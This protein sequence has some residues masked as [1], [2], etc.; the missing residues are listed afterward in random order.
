[1]LHAL[2]YGISRPTATR[3]SHDH[4]SI[5]IHVSTSTVYCMGLLCAAANKRIWNFLAIDHSPTSAFM[6]CHAHIHMPKPAFNLTSRCHRSNYLVH[7]Y[8]LTWPC[9]WLAVLCNFCDAHAQPAQPC[10][11]IKHMGCTCTHFH[12][13]PVCSRSD[14]QGFQFAHISNNQ[15]FTCAAGFRSNIY[16]FP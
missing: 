2:R 3:L 12:P 9:S 16:T 10:R 15:K 14:T 4:S 6:P 13:H 8:K 7:M 5:S 11:L 1:M